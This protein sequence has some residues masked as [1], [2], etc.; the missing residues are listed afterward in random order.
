MSLLFLDSVLTASPIVNIEGKVIFPPSFPVSLGR[1][2]RVIFFRRIVYGPPEID[3]ITFVNDKFGYRTFKM[4][5]KYYI[6][7][8]V[9]YKQFAS[10]FP[11]SLRVGADEK[12]TSYWFIVYFV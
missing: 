3:S 7:E 1:E 6:N 8:T 4:N 9:F 10:F 12:F 5:G 2:F 11:V